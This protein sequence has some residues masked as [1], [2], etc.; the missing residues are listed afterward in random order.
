MFTLLKGFMVTN[1]NR[2]AHVR[3]AQALLLV[4]LS[5]SSL[6]LAQDTSRRGADALRDS[7]QVLYAPVYAHIFSRPSERTSDLT[8]TLNVRN[9]SRES[10]FT[11][12]WVD[13]YDSAGT[14]VRSCPDGPRELG[15]LVLIKFVREERDTTGGAL[16]NFI[17]EGY[18]QHDV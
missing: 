15:P 7:G 17:A 3:R 16:A 6:S 10:A 1:M 13:Y 12:A 5:G 14:L 2:L 9:T 11:L 8:T 18:N 4:T